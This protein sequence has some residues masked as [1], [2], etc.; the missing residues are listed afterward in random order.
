MPVFLCLLSRSTPT[1]DSSFAVSHSLAANV[2][3]QNIYDRQSS[4]ISN[5]ANN[6]WYDYDQLATALVEHETLDAEEVRKDQ[7]LGP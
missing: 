1:V 6:A 7:L 4:T 3:A 2:T 5:Y